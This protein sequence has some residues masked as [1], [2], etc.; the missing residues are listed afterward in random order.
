LTSKP[1]SFYADPP[2]LHK[3]QTFAFVLLP[4]GLHFRNK[5]AQITPFPDCS[6]QH[7]SISPYQKRFPRTNL[8]SIALSGRHRQQSDP[9]QHRPEPPP[10]QM[11]LGEIKPVVPRM[12][13]QPSAG[14][15]QPLLQTGERPLL[16]S[17]G[18]RQPPLQK[19]RAVEGRTVRYV[20]ILPKSP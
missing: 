16:D 20:S 13:Y 15:H 9:A 17:A 3:V 2:A 11:S 7:L 5:T 10:V 4:F 8:T 19:R 6:F 1:A 18:Q 12:F 14:L